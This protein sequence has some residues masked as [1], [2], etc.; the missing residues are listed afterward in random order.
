M[1][2]QYQLALGRGMES[3]AAV[4]HW[5]VERT[6]WAVRRRRKKKRRMH[7]A[8]ESPTPAGMVERA[9]GWGWFSKAGSRHGCSFLLT[10]P[11]LAQK[12]TSGMFRQ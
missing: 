6:G 5:E 2:C 8:E 3:W 12:S 7:L 1:Y 10:Q 9:P 4:E 11:A